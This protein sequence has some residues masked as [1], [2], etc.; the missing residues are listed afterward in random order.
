LLINEQPE[1]S[2]RETEI[3]HL[4][5]SGI[6]DKQI[7]SQLGLAPGTIRTYWER[8]RSKLL[9]ANRAQALSMVLAREHKKAL[10]DLR[11]SE[12]SLTL[13][14]ESP[15]NTAIFI[16]DKNGIV[17]SWKIGV[18]NV[19]GHTGEQFVGEPYSGIFI[20]GDLLS[21]AAGD[22]LEKPLP[23]EPLHQKSDGTLVAICSLSRLPKSA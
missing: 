16:L 10:E 1:L 17:T 7:A 20:E 5:A 22:E 9:A 4:A 12:L 2:G 3:L 21:D 19:L 8:V 6:T 18:Q 14:L 13:T 11:L 23:E 15:D